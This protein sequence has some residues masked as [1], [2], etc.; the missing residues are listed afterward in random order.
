MLHL[1]HCGDCDALSLGLPADDLTSYGPT[2]RAAVPAEA[3]DFLTDLA[4]EQ[5]LWPG[6]GLLPPQ[7]WRP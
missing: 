5:P 2:E 1:V 4:T 3:D 6:D 7:C